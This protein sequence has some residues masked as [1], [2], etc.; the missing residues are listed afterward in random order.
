MVRPHLGLADIL[1]EA[2]LLA[3][4]PAAA[5]VLQENLS[6]EL[7][8]VKDWYRRNYANLCDYWKSRIKGDANGDGKV[9]VADIVEIVNYILKIPSECFN[10]ENANINDDDV[11][12]GEDVKAVVDIIMKT[13]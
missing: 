6:V 7:D 11:I 10:K 13:E 1:H 2:A 12:D 9:N 4:A 5:G 3:T 8:Y